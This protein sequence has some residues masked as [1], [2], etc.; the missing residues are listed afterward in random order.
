[1]EAAE[2]L[3]ISL[4]TLYILVNK[5]EI[6]HYK[7]GSRKLYFKKSQLKSWLENSNN[8]KKEVVNG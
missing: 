8:R 4:S 7:P 5:N 1:M 6:P 2:L 3:G